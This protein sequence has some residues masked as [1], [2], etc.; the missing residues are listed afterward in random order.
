[1]I[2]LADFSPTPD[3]KPAV[4][5]GGRT[6]RPNDAPPIDAASIE[7]GF[8]AQFMQ[9][10]TQQARPDPD[11]DLEVDSDVEVVQDTADVI[12][13]ESDA[14]AS[15]DL[16]AENAA[17]QQLLA[18]L[19]PTAGI[20]LKAGLNDTATLDETND[21][22]DV[23]SSTAKLPMSSAQTRDVQSLAHTGPNR[24]DAGD[25]ALEHTGQRPAPDTRHTPNPAPAAQAEAIQQAALTGLPSSEQAS[26][27]LASNQTLLPAALNTTFISSSATPVPAPATL[28]VATPFNQ[29]DWGRAMMQQV[30]Q[31][32]ANGKHIQ[33]AQLRLNPPDLGALQVTL[34]IE[35]THAQAWFAS[36]HSHVR[37][38]VH[39][40]LPELAQQLQQSGLA[41]GDAQVGSE[42]RRFA[43]SEQ[44]F[45]NNPSQGQSSSQSSSQ[46]P[47]KNSS[48]GSTPPAQSGSVPTQ[49]H[50]TRASGLL[51]V[52]TYA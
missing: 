3:A 26:Q 47:A 30:V 36:P 8:A 45:A 28:P 52:D 1:M 24:L 31:T 29:A 35:G 37:E 38:A 19:N 9:H 15:D 51:R 49:T 11:V 18:L 25:L 13:A 22:N 27:P 32:L 23:N 10:F 40:A 6:M 16:L 4:K 48:Q 44:A 43:A 20:Q 46:T 5:N 2:V 33:H 17:A 14:P 50:A 42:Q 21:V 39:N 12:E 34:R 41:L 7:G